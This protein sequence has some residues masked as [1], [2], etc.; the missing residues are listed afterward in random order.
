MHALYR[1]EAGSFALSNLEGSASS[2]TAGSAAQPTQWCAD[3]PRHR[4]YFRTCPRISPELLCLCRPLDILYSPG[5]K[6]QAQTGW[7]GTSCGETIM[8]QTYQCVFKSDL[9]IENNAA[10][11]PATL[12]SPVEELPLCGQGRIWRQLHR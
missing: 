9:S 1:K 8:P 7:A 5:D 3:Y 10:A 6:Q 4:H 12:F 11:S 2:S